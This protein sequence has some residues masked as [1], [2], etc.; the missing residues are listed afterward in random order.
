MKTIQITDRH[1]TALRMVAA[2]LDTTLTETMRRIL[3]GDTEALEHL[4]QYV[5]P[6]DDR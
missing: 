3:D 6:G 1:H 4:R 2:Q 5:E